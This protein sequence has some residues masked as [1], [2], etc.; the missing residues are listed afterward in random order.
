MNANKPNRKALFNFYNREGGYAVLIPKY[1]QHIQDIRQLYD[2]QRD[3]FED[4]PAKPTMWMRTMIRSDIIRNRVAER[5]SL[6]P[7]SNVLDLGCG[8]GYLSYRMAK[9]RFTVTGI[10]I[11][12]P[13]VKTSRCVAQFGGVGSNRFLVGDAENIPCRKSFFSLIL[14]SEVFE[15]LPD[16][17]KAIHEIGRVAKREAVLILTTPNKYNIYE[18]LALAK[19][20]VMRLFR[21]GRPLPLGV[22]HISVCSSR[23][24][25]PVSY[26]HLT[27]PTKA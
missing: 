8:D 13:R 17:L 25:R 27:L 14:F 22:G 19:R 4:Y 10:D 18:N 20:N 3:G 11:S 12:L 5:K 6:L 2:F 24:I 1:L 9:V 21:K 26:T 23:I 7:G 16:P 15:H